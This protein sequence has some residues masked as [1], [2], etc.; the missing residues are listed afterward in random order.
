MT[1]K[2]ILI[3]K[4]VHYDFNSSISIGFSIEDHRWWFFPRVTSMRWLGCHRMHNNNNMGGLRKLKKNLKNDNVYM[5]NDWV[6]SAEPLNQGYYH[7]IN[8]TTLSQLKVNVGP[9]AAVLLKLGAEHHSRLLNAI[10]TCIMIGLYNND[11]VIYLE[12]CIARFAEM[13]GK[14]IRELFI[15]ATERF[16]NNTDKTDLE[17]VQIRQYLKEMLELSEDEIAQKFLDGSINFE[18]IGKAMDKVDEDNG[19][20]Q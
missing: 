11:F 5:L 16:E 20:K 10:Q 13:L 15:N 1:K 9:N 12:K 2:I 6:L 7:A 17:D 18:L 19:D 8:S 4:F 3:T 14:T